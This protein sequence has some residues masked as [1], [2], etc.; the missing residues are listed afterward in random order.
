MNKPGRPKQDEKKPV[1]VLERVILAIYAYG[2]ARK[3]GEKHSVAISEA[4]E[5]IRN[6]APAMRVSETGIKRIVATW[7]PK[8]SATCLF[9]DKPDPEHNSIPPYA[10]RKGTVLYTVSVRP[11]PIYPRAN[12]AEKPRRR[13]KP[14][15]F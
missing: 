12:A 1:W 13:R 15:S 11:R 14:R 10:R 5:Y 9:V 2:R 7:R 4:V 8:R 6:T 3:A